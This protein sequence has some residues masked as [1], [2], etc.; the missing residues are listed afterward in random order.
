ML[1]SRKRLKYPRSGVGAKVMQ[2]DGLQT[3]EVVERIDGVIQRR[4]VLV[5]DRGAL[6]T[7][8]ICSAKLP[9]QC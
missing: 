3:C 1:Y 7:L 5:Q 8:A 9:L 6:A 4:N 2:R